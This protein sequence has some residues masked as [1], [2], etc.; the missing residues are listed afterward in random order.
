MQDFFFQR[1]NKGVHCNQRTMTQYN[2]DHRYAF[3]TGVIR[4]CET[5]MITKELVDQLIRAD[6]LTKIVELLRNTV[7]QDFLG[8]DDASHA[9]ERVPH[10]RK[11][12]LFRF[13]D[14]HAPHEELS[15]LLRV[16]YDYHNIKILLKERIFEQENAAALVD[17][18]TVNREKL[19]DVFTNENYETLPPFMY[20]GVVEAVDAYYATRH[21]ILLDLTMD[22]NMFED[23]LDRAKKVESRLLVEHFR[24]AIDLLNLQTA[25][26]A[27][28]MS[29]ETA[30]R[31][32]LFIPG[33]EIDLD[34]LWALVDGGVKEVAAVAAEFGLDRISRAAAEVPAN[35]F[36]IER[37]SDN[38]LLDHLRP[39]RFLIWGVE[40][41]FS[42]GFAVEMELKI[43]GI[44]INCRRAGLS[45]EWIK[46]RLPEPF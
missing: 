13:L 30:I 7:Y 3:M 19:M 16:G 26:R 31:E 24:M 15:E 44:I 36:A 39:T 12:W 28:E 37:E 43:L 25:L 34:I 1:V 8:N 6:S 2:N 46:K 33:G 41:A 5:K 10:L 45:P 21:A 42:F 29:Q 23:L 17:M 27:K 35:P 11:D 32:S 22:R 14:A 9:L 18:G 4:A 20:K 38:T 40:P